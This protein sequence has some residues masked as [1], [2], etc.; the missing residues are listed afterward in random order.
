MGA[1]LYISKI[2]KDILTE[3][4]EPIKQ[5]AVQS[6]LD[7]IR[8]TKAQVYQSYRTALASQTVMEKMLAIQE[9]TDEKKGMSNK[10][11]IAYQTAKESHNKAL[12]TYR[13]SV[14]NPDFNLQKIATKNWEI[15][16]ELKAEEALKFSKKIKLL[17]SLLS[18]G[19]GV[20]LKTVLINALFAIEEAR[21]VFQKPIKYSIAMHVEGSEQVKEGYY[22]LQ[23]L[24]NMGAIGIAENNVLN[25]YNTVSLTVTM[26]RSMMS[27]M[28]DLSLYGSNYILNSQSNKN[29]GWKYQFFKEKEIYGLSL[30]KQDNKT[31]SAGPDIEA[32]G[33]N[34]YGLQ[35]KFMNFTEN[36]YISTL[37]I[38]SLNTILASLEAYEFKLENALAQKQIDFNKIELKNITKSFKENIVAQLQ[39]KI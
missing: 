12:H 4:T 1:E 34:S 26:N 18:I 20:D 32:I 29:R 27:S 5:E 16:R 22:S 35:A 13:S 3:K 30:L 36:A 6:A 19:A 39:Q 21:D 2:V 24:Y 7:K 25:I 33:K 31:W 38:S 15:Y 28:K 14:K 10:L 9:Y 37:Q 8:E 23:E 17:P 11:N